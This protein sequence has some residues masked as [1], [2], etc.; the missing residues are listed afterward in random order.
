MACPTQ[1]T[2]SPH[3]A[4]YTTNTMHGS[5][6]LQQHIASLDIH[7][8][9]QLFGEGRAAKVGC[10]S[11]LEWMDKCVLSLSQLSRSMQLQ[12]S[13]GALFPSTLLTLTLQISNIRTQTLIDS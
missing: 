11:L 9:T 13:G 12:L 6:I 10:N 2:L 8:Y 4:L 1:T 7:K 5:H 3:R